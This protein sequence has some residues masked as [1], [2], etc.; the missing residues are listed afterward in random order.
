MGSEGGLASCV[1]RPP[2]AHGVVK[3]V[4]LP[5]EPETQASWQKANFH[6]HA[7]LGKAWDDRVRRDTLVME[8]SISLHC[9]SHQGPDV[10]LL[11]CMLPRMM[12]ERPRLTDTCQ[13]A[14]PSVI[15]L[16]WVWS[17]HGHECKSLLKTYRGICV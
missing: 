10:K 15:Q 14:R 16:N 1:Y 4:S 2:L 9:A 3:A 11:V 6:H 17:C 5:R 8:G 7:L 13:K 12:E